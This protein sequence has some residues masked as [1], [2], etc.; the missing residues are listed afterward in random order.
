MKFYETASLEARQYVA[1]DPAAD[2]PEKEEEYIT[3]FLKDFVEYSLVTLGA[4]QTI[5]ELI[6]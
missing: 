6:A 2:T 5:E 4:N 3:N 1:I